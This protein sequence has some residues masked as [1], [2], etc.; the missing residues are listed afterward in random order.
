MCIG[1][2]PTPGSAFHH[3][4]PRTQTRLSHPSSIDPQRQAQN[5]QALANTFKLISESTSQQE[6]AWEKA[7]ERM[8][9][10]RTVRERLE[11]MLLLLLGPMAFWK[12]WFEG[13]EYDEGGCDGC[14]QIYYCWSLRVGT[15]SSGRLTRVPSAIKQKLPVIPTTQKDTRSQK[16]RDVRHRRYPRITTTRTYL[17]AVHG[18]S[19]PR[20]N[21]EDEADVL[22]CRRRRVVVVVVGH[23]RM[24]AA[25]RW[26]GRIARLCCRC[27]LQGVQPGP[28]TRERYRLRL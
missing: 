13:E 10:E 25:L 1:L 21:E 19:S 4:D 14:V 8:R 9:E 23:I 24:T 3:F 5:K 26:R 22:R 2:N 11:L 18:L 15:C 17:N 20:G 16:K 27:L 12:R 28:D 6:E 7:V